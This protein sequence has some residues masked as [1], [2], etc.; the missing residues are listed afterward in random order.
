MTFTIHPNAEKILNEPSFAIFKHADL[1][2]CISRMMHR[3]GCNGYVAVPKE[4]PFY[5]KGYSDKIEIANIEEI[6][7]NGNYIGLLCNSI[8]S[9]NPNTLSLDLAINVH[10]GITYAH[11]E[12]GGIEKDLLGEL[13]W[14]GFDTGHCDDLNPFQSDIDRRFP[15]GANVVY[16][17][18][19][20]VKEQTKQMA[21]QLAT[22]KN[23]PL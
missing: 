22:F 17:D 7:F 19:E 13:W 10:G 14:F 9:D 8:D 1:Y 15:L 16:R 6:P 23:K 20:W 18:F 5:G 3:G 2:C 21:E 4:H 11:G 12:L